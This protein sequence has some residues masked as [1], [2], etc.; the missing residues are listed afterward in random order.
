VEPWYAA[1]SEPG[2]LTCAARS[3]VD[4]DLSPQGW[5]RN[6]DIGHLGLSSCYGSGDSPRSPKRNRQKTM[7]HLGCGTERPGAPQNHLRSHIQ[8]CMISPQVPDFRERSDRAAYGGDHVGKPSRKNYACGDWTSHRVRLVESCC[9][10]LLAGLVTALGFLAGRPPSS[11]LGLN[12]RLRI[13]DQKREKNCRNFRR[14]RQS[15]S[16]YGRTQPDVWD[17]KICYRSSTK[18]LRSKCRRSVHAKPRVMTSNNGAIR[19]RA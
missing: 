3:I 18:S 12:Q 7:M 1:I 8:R 5:G 13:P 15:N 6:G 9:G 14:L 17:T 4:F 2:T 10:A 16:A 11:S 19:N